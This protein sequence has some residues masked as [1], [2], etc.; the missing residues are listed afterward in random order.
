MI[1]VKGD[2][3]AD[4][5]M[6][7][8]SNRYFPEGKELTKNDYV[9]IAGDFGI[10]FIDEYHLKWLRNKPWTTLI[11]RGNHDNTEIIRNLPVEDLLDKKVKKLYNSIYLLEDTEIYTIEGKKFFIFGGAMSIDT[12]RRTQGKDWWPDEVPSYA[13]YMRGMDNLEK[14]N[15]KIDY[16][17]S[18]TCPISIL[19]K[20]FG[21][22]DVDSHKGLDATSNMLESFFN[23]IEF[24]KWYFGH[25]HIDTRID[26]K[27]IATYH[28][29]HKILT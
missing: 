27:F 6:N 4:I 25:M 11:V 2:T 13:D 16:V 18:H 22:Y 8:L 28:K 9:I 10:G 7:D 14:V 23:V 1:F 24:D 3:H 19:S 20:I 5:D 21:K 26:D 29:V 15:N 17:I 12:Y